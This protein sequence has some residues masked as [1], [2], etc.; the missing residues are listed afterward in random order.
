LK[1]IY[2]T[3]LNQTLQLLAQENI[4]YGQIQ[5]KFQEVTAENSRLRREFEEHLHEENQK[6]EKKL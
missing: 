5:E 1:K 6:W 2:D 4:K 3:E